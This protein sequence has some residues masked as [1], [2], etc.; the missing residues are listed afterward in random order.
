MARVWQVK[1]QTGES[2]VGEPYYTKYI[3]IDTT[4]ES[5]RRVE[6]MWRH[7]YEKDMFEGT[8]LEV[9]YLHETDVVEVTAKQLAMVAGRSQFFKLK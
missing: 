3:F 6:L 1:A 2:P 5:K 4:N 9:T 8:K 7:A